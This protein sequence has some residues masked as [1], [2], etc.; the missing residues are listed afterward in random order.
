[1]RFIAELVRV[2]VVDQTRLMADEAGFYVRMG[3]H[4][5]YGFTADSC[6]QYVRGDIHTNTVEG[7]FSIFE[8]G[9][10]GV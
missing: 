7:Y 1:M 2:G 6:G 9:M 8:C 10:K 5:E 4:Y 3:P